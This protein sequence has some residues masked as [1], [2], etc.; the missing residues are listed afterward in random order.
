MWIH[1]VT[2]AVVAITKPVTIANC[3]PVLEQIGEIVCEKKMRFVSPGT[4]SSHSELRTL[5]TSWALC[6][7]QPGYEVHTYLPLFSFRN[8]VWK[9]TLLTMV[10]QQ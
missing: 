1:F 8:T 10:T 4:D 7:W 6:L 9:E 3:T 2:S 5:I